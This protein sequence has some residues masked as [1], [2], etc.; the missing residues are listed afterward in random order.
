MKD[1][2]HICPRTK[3]VEKLAAVVE[4]HG[5]AHLRGTPCSGKTTLAYLLEDYYIECGQPVV[6]IPCWHSASYSVNPTDYIINECKAQGHDEIGRHN[7]LTSN[8]VIILDEAQSSYHDLHLWIEIIKVANDPR[9]DLKFCLLSSYGSPS[10]G[11]TEYPDTIIPA[12]FCAE[13]R[14]SITTS[15]FATN[16]GICLFYTDDEFKEV[17]KKLCSNPI[18]TFTLDCTAR[19]YLYSVTNGHPGAT[20]SLIKVIF[21]VCM[22]YSMY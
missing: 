4:E 15:S 10:V 20:N 11:S 16:G 21:A 8:L 5:V 3:T 9:I 2:P 19:D 18:S 14:I 7:L 17:V 1:Y 12:E 13:Q 6:F 22:T